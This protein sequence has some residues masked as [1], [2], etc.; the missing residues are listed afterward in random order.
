[1]PPIRSLVSKRSLYHS[2]L[3]AVIFLLG[4]IMP[5]YSYCAKKKLVCVIIVALSSH[6]PFFYSK[7]TKLNICSSCNIQL[8]SDAKYIFFTI[9][10]YFPHSLG[11]N[12]WWY[13]IFLALY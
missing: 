7:C 2:K 13:I 5:I 11:A 12:T 8:V 1:M 10:F 3:V 4:K 9:L 6:Q